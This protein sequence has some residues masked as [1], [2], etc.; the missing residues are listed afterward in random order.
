MNKASRFPLPQEPA[1][2][3]AQRLLC[4]DRHYYSCL[5]ASAI[6]ANKCGNVVVACNPNSGCEYIKQYD[7]EHGL[8][9]RIYNENE[10]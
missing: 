1:E 3:A 8:Q 4:P 2:R 6:I 7:K 9:E 10:E 5:K